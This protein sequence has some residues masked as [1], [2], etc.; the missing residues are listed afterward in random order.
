M[1]E[2]LLNCP[3][4]GGEASVEEVDHYGKTMFSCGCTTE[5]CM[6]YQSMAVFNRKKEVVQYWNT[7]HQT[8]EVSELQKEVSRLTMLKDGQKEFK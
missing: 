2:K 8:T 6:G 1:S 3:F 7:R 5:N 4:C